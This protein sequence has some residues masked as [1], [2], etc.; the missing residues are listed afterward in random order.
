MNKTALTTIQGVLICICFCAATGAAGAA[1]PGAVS[2]GGLVSRLESLENR[3]GLLERKGRSAIDRLRSIELLIFGVEQT[4][5][6]LARVD[7]AEKQLSAGQSSD[8]PGLPQAPPV[9]IKS[10]PPQSPPAVPDRTF[11]LKGGL[12]LPPVNVY[13]PRFL[14]ID[15]PGEELSPLDYFR[16]VMKAGR[17]KVFRFKDLPIPV[18]ITPVQIP[19]YRQACIKGFERWE[20]STGG[21]VRFAEVDDPEEARIRV[22]WSRLGLNTDSKGCTLGAHTTTKWRSKGSGKMAVVGVAGVPV[23]I[24]IPKFG[25]KYSVH[26]QIIEVNLDLIFSKATDIRMRILENIVTHELGHALGL[27]GHSP[28]KTD[29]M[30]PLTDEHSRLSA[31]DVNTLIRIYSKD[32]DIPL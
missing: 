8:P 23:P 32:A 22:I 5:S 6:V 30:Y 16:D 11:D 18:Y 20:E 19:G 2:G 10:G 28:F 4:G 31:R 12:V 15:P 13:S 27:F 17:G 26:P 25:P 14:R 1:E 29:I 21:R 3:T 7:R 24:Y 9:E